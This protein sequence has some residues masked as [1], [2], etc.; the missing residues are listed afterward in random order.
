[1][2]VKFG[3]IPSRI[4]LPTDQNCT[5]IPTNHS[6]LHIIF[7]LDVAIH[8]WCNLPNSA[9]LFLYHEIP[10]TARNVNYYSAESVVNEAPD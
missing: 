9:F 5:S 7:I 10:Y 1:M 8:T 4:K 6:I 2:E 3:D